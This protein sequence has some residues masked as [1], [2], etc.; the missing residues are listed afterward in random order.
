M[1]KNWSGEQFIVIHPKRGLQ[2]QT[3]IKSSSFNNLDLYVSTSFTHP[4]WLRKI[5]HSFVTR[6]VFEFQFCH[7]FQKQNSNRTKVPLRQ[8]SRTIHLVTRC[9]ACL[10]E[11]PFPTVWRTSTSK[12]VGSPCNQGLHF[13]L[14]LCEVG[15]SCPLYKTLNADFPTV[16]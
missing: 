4:I 14:T 16:H 10:H 9:G 2:S 3:I 8:K 5:F 15:Y 12:A 7:W 6:H 13:H 1:V 11:S